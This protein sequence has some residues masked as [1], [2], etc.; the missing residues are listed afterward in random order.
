MPRLGN[1][2]ISW[3]TSMVCGSSFLSTCDNKVGQTEAAFQFTF[4][5]KRGHYEIVMA[6]Y[7]DR[8]WSEASTESKPYPAQKLSL[9]AIRCARRCKKPNA[10]VESSGIQ[11][12]IYKNNVWKKTFL[13]KSSQQN[14]LPPGPR[15]KISASGSTSVP[16]NNVSNTL[17]PTDQDKNR[18]L[19]TQRLH[20]L[21]EPNFSS[22]TPP[23]H[24]IETDGNPVSGVAMPISI[25][26]DR[27]ILIKL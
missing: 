25:N 10:L 22:F 27:I 21:G 19:V 16:T 2:R 18:F 9:L 23:A 13:L 20:L 24:T 7:L 12:T 4:K 17:V 15:T 26:I 5:K 1:D 14:F 11:A 3:V 6:D 8:R